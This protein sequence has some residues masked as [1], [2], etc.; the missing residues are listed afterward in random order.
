MTGAAPGAFEGIAVSSAL[1]ARQR[2]NQVLSFLNW[3]RICEL[4]GPN[5]VVGFTCGFHRLSM[6]YACRC[7]EGC[8]ERRR[9]HVCVVGAMDISFRACVCVH[10]GGGKR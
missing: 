7:L 10:G 8:Q 9:L 1:S 2:K 3:Q 6:G 4:E 5:G